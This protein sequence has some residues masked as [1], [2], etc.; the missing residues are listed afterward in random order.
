MVGAGLG[1]MADGAPGSGGMPNGGGMAVNGG[2]PAN[3]GEAGGLFSGLTTTPSPSMIA[4]AMA[5]APTM[6]LVPEH[7]LSPT[8]ARPSRGDSLGGFSDSSSLGAP[9]KPPPAMELSS[10]RGPRV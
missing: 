10:R 9:P 7:G 8:D 1:M 2:M 3:G 6:P 5:L 4:P